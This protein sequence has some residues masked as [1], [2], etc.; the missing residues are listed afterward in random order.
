MIMNMKTLLKK[1]AALKVF[2]FCIMLLTGFSLS[3]Q[4]IYF[5]EDFSNP[6]A[7]DSIADWQ[8]INDGGTTGQTWMFDNPGNRT[9]VGADFD[10]SFAILDS[11]FYGSGNN[12]DASLISPSID[13]STSTSAEVFLTFSESYRHVSSSG[14][15]DYSTDGGVTWNNLVTRTSSTGYPDPITASFDVTSL[16]GESDVRFRWK[17]VGSWGWWWA[18][19]NV[20]LVGTNCLTPSNFTA[21]KTGQTDVTFDWDTV[22]G[23]DFY[24]LVYENTS[25]GDLDTILNIT[26]NF[27]ALSGLDSNVVYNAF[28]AAIC[29]LELGSPAQT[30][31]ETFGP[32]ADCSNPIM[33]TSLPYTTTDNTENY[34]DVYS[35][36][37]GSSGCGTTSAYLNGDDVVY[38]YTADFTGNIDITMSPVGS[39]SG[40]FIYADCADIGTACLDGVASS[41]TADRIIDFFP[42]DSGDTYYIVISTWAAPQTVGYT[43]TIEPSPTCFEPE[44]ITITELSFDYVSGSWTEVGP[45][46]E[47]QIEGGPQGFP[48][49]LGD[50]FNVF[51]TPEFSVDGLDPNT[52]YEFYI[53]SVC[54][55]G[56]TSDWLGPIGFRT[57][58]TPFAA[59]YL[60][61][62]DDNIWVSG[63]GANNINSEIDSCWFRTPSENNV[64]AWGTRTGTTGSINT[65]PSGDNTTGSGNY[66]FTEAGN[67]SEGDLADF[68]SPPIDLTSL[69]LPEL[70]F[71]YHMYGNHIDTFSVAINNGSGWDI[72]QTL[73][74]EQQTSSSAPYIPSQI[75]LDNYVGDT[76]QVRFRVRKGSSFNGDV[77]IDDFEI[78]EAP[79]CITPDNIAV[80]N[81]ST[82][83]ATAVWSPV[84]GAV[85]YDVALLDAGETFNDSATFTAITDTF[86]NLTALDF[87]AD[88]DVYVRVICATDTSD[89]NF[90][91]VTFSTICITPLSGTYTINAFGNGD[92]I[93][94]TEAVE[95]LVNCGVSGPV[96]INV[97]SAT[98]NEQIIIPAIPG[99]SSTNTI[100]FTSANPEES[101]ISYEDQVSADRYVIQLDG[102][103]HL[104]IDNLGI[105][106]L[107]SDF[108]WGIHLTNNAD[109]IN[110]TNNIILLD[111]T[112]TLVSNVGGIIA[113][114]SN[115]L[116]TSNGENANNLLIEGNTIIGGYHNIR[117]NGSSLAQSQG[118]VIRDNIL[119]DAHA[120]GIYTDQLAAHLIFGNEVTR[121]TRTV[122]AIYYGIRVSNSSQFEI[123]SNKIYDIYEEAPSTTFYG[124]YINASSAIASNPNLIANNLIYNIDNPSSISYVI[125]HLAS[126]FTNIY[127]NTISLVDDN[128][129]SANY[130]Y[131][132]STAAD[133]IEVKNNIFEAIN[134]GTGTIRALWFAQATTGFISDNNVFN[135]EGSGSE[136]TLGRLGLTNYADLSSWQTASTQDGNSVEEDPSFANA[137]N[138]IFIPTNPAIDGIGDPAVTSIVPLDIDGE[139]RDANPD[140]GAYE[141]TPPDNDIALETILAPL[142]DQCYTSTEIAQVLVSNQGLQDLNFAD[143]SL[144][145]TLIV[146]GILPQTFNTVINT[147]TL[148]VGDTL[149]I[150]ITSVLDMSLEGLYEFTF[151]ANLQDDGNP[152][153]DTL[154]L[155]IN[156]S[157]GVIV[158]NNTEV[159]FGEEAS[160]VLTD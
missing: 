67:G 144:E 100:T 76:I 155:S 60:E 95:E 3:A 88:Y 143:D 41:T 125:R 25:S 6:I 157:P 134:A 19:D 68:I 75:I 31:F 140:P 23:A 159:C 13:L 71:Y 90:T 17:Y 158:T 64:F 146:D 139:T 79:A 49:G 89:W 39:W 133:N 77:A 81:L 120:Y 46:T 107:S 85:N 93:S 86:F 104:T 62:F 96:V 40:I 70:R 54:A 2:T 156:R 27:Y 47:W 113:S 12:Q 53:R 16:K 56:D 22:P 83:S 117:L 32:G 131:Y 137:A 29:G 122:S 84:T 65:G 135:I 94:F 66:I 80:I 118:I 145:I 9:L 8:N 21:T 74:G 87:L 92:F 28:V 44:D 20:M 52:D 99:A 151:I 108:G 61:T 141:F 154:T 129:T 69:T 123:N 37:P 138:G 109:S 10:T 15:L 149:S 160:L 36:S 130:L 50:R 55:V 91:P 34:F 121:P 35:G 128:K 97:D 98:Y 45:A 26:D 42:V 136:I 14:S 38:A 18:I 124:I 142:P 48:L 73:V 24:V 1:K 7:S 78:R 5:S 132:H 114:N 103:S 43:L 72:V 82:N 33:I 51:G 57:I 147:G 105:H 148:V 152:F 63:T 101:I 112:N 119:Q 59:P 30:S 11:D 102:T 4:N 153:N 111:K 150:E 106:A 126:D 58:C 116:A 110:L 115:T 127:H